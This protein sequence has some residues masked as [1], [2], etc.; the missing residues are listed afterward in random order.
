MAQWGRNDQSV[1]ADGTTTKET[2]NGAPIGTGLLVKFGG[3]NTS[4]RVDGANAHFGNTSAGSRANVDV[5]MFEN[6]TMDAFIPGKAVGVYGVDTTEMGF[7]SGKIGITRITSAGSGYGANAAFVTITVTNGGT[8]GV[9]N[10]Y[11]NSTTLAGKITALNIQTAGSGYITDPT[12]AIA[13]PAAI[14]I[15]AN[16]NSITLSKFISVASANSKWQVGDRFYYGVPASNTAIPGLTGNTYYYVS[17]ANT[18]GICVANTPTGA[19]LTLTPATTTPGEVHTI[20]GDTATGYV[21]VSGA[22]NNGVTH[23]GWVL[24]TEGSGGRAGR[25]QYETLVAMGSLGAQTAPYGTPAT[26]ADGND[27]NLLQDS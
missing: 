2:S 22:K 27:D 11:A 15:T 24:R 23:A 25:V 18:T 17:F 19:N 3:Q 12:I 14:N 16:T 10:A 9:V 6:Y 13:P 7:S 4:V 5:Q 8:S 1:T 26:T 20:Q 21:L